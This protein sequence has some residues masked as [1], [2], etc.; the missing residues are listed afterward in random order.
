MRIKKC[1]MLRLKIKKSVILKGIITNVVILSPLLAMYGT[2]IATITILDLSLII[3]SILILSNQMTSSKLKLNPNV[4]ILVILIIGIL[5][6][7]LFNSFFYDK[8]KFIEVF[9]RTIRFSYYL[10]FLMLII[11]DLFSE[12]L[13]LKIY[14]YV[15]IFATFYLIIQNI[16][17][18][19]FGISLKGYIPFLPV[20][21][22]ELIHFTENL[23]ATSWARP[24]SIFAE[25]SQYGLYVSGYLALSLYKSNIKDSMFIKIF[26]SGGCIL[27]VS[28]T[29][30]LVVLLLWIVKIFK[31]LKKNINNFVVILVISIILFS[32]IFL[33]YSNTSKFDLFIQRIGISFQNR[34]GG[35]IAYND[36]IQ[37]NSSL[38]IILF[39]SG[40]DLNI[41]TTWASGLARIL[42]YY[43]LMGFTF[44]IL[45][46][47][48][49]SLNITKDKKSYL[50]VI[51]L[52]G[53]FSELWLSNWILL[54]LPFVLMK[55]ENDI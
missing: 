54:F 16:L 52:M 13:A 25:P 7:F 19:G 22:D 5:V 36:F 24:R 39:G 55:Q 30:I 17:L 48:Y 11:N 47:L 40:M 3:L 53:I 34:F 50:N 14:K 2:G 18:F 46:F 37:Q 35:F 31:Y 32:I 27:S 42:F 28:T 1:S 51:F 41:I 10:F 6:N 21:R 20:M 29:A 4:K 45:A 38:R 15:A 9:L 33:I 23:S 49:L 12:E 8:T 44:F 26:L 43:G